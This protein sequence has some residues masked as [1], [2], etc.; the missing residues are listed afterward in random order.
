MHP[1][2]EE[3]ELYAFHKLAPAKISVIETH[4]EV[5]EICRKKL[6]EGEEFSGQLH[7]LRQAHR[8]GTGAEQRRSRRISTNDSAVAK[9]L[10]AG[11]ESLMD[12]RVLDVSAGGVCLQVPQAV[13]PGTAIQVN[14]GNTLVKGEVRYCI[15]ADGSFRLGVQI[16]DVLTPIDPASA[17]AVIKPER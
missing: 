16:E 5:C 15:E 6:R 3:L 14:L 1:A 7:N 10:E 11:S 12:A 13:R 4:L 9:I 2:A 17:S 8:T